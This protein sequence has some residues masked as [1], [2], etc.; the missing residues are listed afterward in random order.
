MYIVFN[1]IILNEVSIIEIAV[2]LVENLMYISCYLYYYF[3]C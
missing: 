2:N 1:Y 3:L